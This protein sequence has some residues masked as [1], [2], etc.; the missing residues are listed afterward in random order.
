MSDLDV[1][2]LTSR[3]EGTPVAL[4]EALAAARPVVATDVGGV[5]FVVEDGVTGLLA[6]LDA[7]VLAS[8]IER[9]LSDRATVG[10]MAVAGRA[11]VAARF[12]HD[13]LVQD[14]RGLYRELIGVP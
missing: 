11:T 1:V 10:A 5:P 7:G 13:R 6:P 8:H 2:V 14:M 4:I 12:S 3:H 9:A